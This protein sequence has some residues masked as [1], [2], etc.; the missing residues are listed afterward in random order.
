MLIQTSH[1]D[2]ETVGIGTRHVERLDAANCAKEML[3]NSRVERVRRE[4]LSA[5][6]Q[7]K[8][9]FG[10]DEMQKAALAANRAVALARFNVDGR[11][12]FEPDP[13]AMAPAAMVNARS[14]I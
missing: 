10:N 9:G 4:I 3:G 8:V 1:V 14:C 5:L 13:P 2:A 7:L 12:H 11:H 6:H